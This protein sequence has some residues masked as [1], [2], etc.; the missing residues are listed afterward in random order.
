MIE[1]GKLKFEKSGGPTEVEYL[2]K[3][4]AKTTRQ[5]KESPREVIP[6]KLQ[7]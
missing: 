3:A 5:E 1:E 4:K 2:F 7:Y 6:K